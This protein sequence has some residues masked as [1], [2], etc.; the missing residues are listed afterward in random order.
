MCVSFSHINIVR[1]YTKNASINLRAF[2][3]LSF[4]GKF[5][6]LRCMDDKPLDHSIISSAPKTS[7][8]SVTLS[9]TISSKNK[10][11]LPMLLGLVVLVIIGV[12]AS[13]FTVSKFVNKAINTEKNI[14]DI[15]SQIS[16]HKKIPSVVVAPA[17]KADPSY[18]EV[19]AG[20]GAKVQLLNSE[21]KLVRE[22]VYSSG[23][24]NGG[25]VELYYAKP[26]SGLY[27]LNIQ[28]LDKL[29]VTV[30]L[31]DREAE[32]R[33]FDFFNDKATSSA[34]FKIKFDKENSKKS[35]TEL[36]Q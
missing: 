3:Y 1:N 9:P 25:G 5:G 36:I 20:P 22:G 10:K 34:K 21:G 26:E 8:A 24:G 16:A 30:L 18:I 2:E 32:V 6:L 31:Y 15:A 4:G 35:I 13:V 28:S 12:G 17:K 33:M 11:L 29:G 19:F 23:I 27:F 14:T 7:D